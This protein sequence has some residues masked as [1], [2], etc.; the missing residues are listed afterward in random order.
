MRSRI[1][2]A[3]KPHRRAGRKWH[4]SNVRDV[5]TRSTYRGKHLY[6]VINTR[7]GIK[8]PE[9][10]W[11]EIPAPVIISEVEWLEV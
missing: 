3:L 2:P 8:W 9:E 6:G 11:Q 4:V 10:E 1:D 7:N 5:L